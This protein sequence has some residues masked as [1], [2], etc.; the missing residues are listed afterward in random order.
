MNQLE[1]TKSAGKT[2]VLFNGVDIA[3]ECLS[4]SLEMSDKGPAILTLKIY[5]ENIDA[6]KTGSAELALLIN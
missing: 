1:I 4:Y 3:G 2:Q 6:T 5:C